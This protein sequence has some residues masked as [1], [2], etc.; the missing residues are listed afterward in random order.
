MLVGG[1]WNPAL[2]G[3][4]M[5]LNEWTSI[6]PPEVIEQHGDVQDWRNLVGTGPFMLTDVVEDSHITWAKNPDYW[7]HDEKYPDNRLPYVD[8]LRM[9]IMR[10][11][12]SIVAA[13][14]SGVARQVRFPGC[15]QIR[16][17]A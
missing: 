14:R 15:G 3:N 10:E 11:E 6:M 4:T 1:L 9:M 12:G 17:W 16:Q 13:L 8:E 7:G 2:A 5:L